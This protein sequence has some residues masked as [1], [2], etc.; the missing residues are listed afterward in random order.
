MIINNERILKSLWHMGLC[1]VGLYE[2]RN[3]KTA[4]SKVLAVGLIGFHADATL[5]DWLDKPTMLQRLLMNL[6]RLRSDNESY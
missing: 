4:V 1:L 6:R 5:C 3:H 2:L